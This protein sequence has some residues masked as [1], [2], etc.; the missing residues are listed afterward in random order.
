MDQNHNTI[1]PN[2]TMIFD[3]PSTSILSKFPTGAQ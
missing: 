1:S 2:R 3:E